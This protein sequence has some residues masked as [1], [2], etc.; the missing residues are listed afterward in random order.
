MI[1]EHYNAKYAAL[2]TGIKVRT[3]QIYL[4]MYNNDAER[5]LPGTYN[6]PP[7]RPLCKLNKF[8]LGFLTK[9]IGNNST[10]ISQR[11]ERNAV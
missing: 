6:N 5:H 7:G 2:L 8:H 3:T 4:K 1:D 11:F 10:L 9:F